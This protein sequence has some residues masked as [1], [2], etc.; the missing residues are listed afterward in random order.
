M[1]HCTEGIICSSQIT[2]TLTSNKGA[3]KE[4]LYSELNS[5]MYHYAAHYEMV[6]FFVNTSMCTATYAACTFRLP[7]EAAIS[8][9]RC[10]NI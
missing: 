5:F 7:F 3:I 4:S 8:P 10:S 2:S 9:Y 1:W 6:N